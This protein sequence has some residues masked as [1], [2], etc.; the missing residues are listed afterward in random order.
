VELVDPAH[1]RELLGARW[2]GLVVQ[3]R[4][5]YLQELALATDRE[6]GPRTAHAAKRMTVAAEVNRPF[7]NLERSARR[8]AWFRDLSRQLGSPRLLE[9]RLRQSLPSNQ[10]C[11]M[12]A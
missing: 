7:S 3:P 1:Q 10:N 5:R 4:A 9:S 2:L 8:R 6:S 12:S 11:A